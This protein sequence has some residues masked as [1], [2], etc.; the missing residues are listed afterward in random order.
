MPLVEQKV[1]INRSG[2]DV[3][4]FMLDFGNTPHWQPNSV[5]LEKAGKVKLGDMI[6]G[7]RRMI[8]RMSYVNADVIDVQPNQRIIF[9]GIMGGYAF[10]TTYQFDFSG[11]GGTQ[12]TIST[13]IRI[14]WFY[15]PLRPFIL[16]GLKGQM[17]TALDNLKD[18]MES[19]RDLS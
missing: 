4:R 18:Y 9:S 11:A 19:R 12:V 7:M 5:R 10:R 2:A 6:V 15:A 13:D 17:T 16:N 8:G 14:P 1:S 3:Y